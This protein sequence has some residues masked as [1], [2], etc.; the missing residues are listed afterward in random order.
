M[1]HPRYVTEE[2]FRKRAITLEPF[3]WA[4]EKLCNVHLHDIGIRQVSFTWL[5]GGV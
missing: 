4:S 3:G 1:S 5:V 2:E